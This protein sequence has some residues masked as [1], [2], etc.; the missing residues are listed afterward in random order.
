MAHRLRQPQLFLSE[1]V[2]R[3][4]ARHCAI[5]GDLGKKGKSG[6]LKSR[7]SRE[8]FLRDKRHRIT[9]HFT[10]CGQNTPPR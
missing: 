8:A 5:E 9:F 4:V 2:V 3:L 1:G 7:A 10:P 6:I